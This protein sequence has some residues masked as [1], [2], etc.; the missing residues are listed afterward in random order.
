MAT[1]GLG[2]PATVSIL[3]T[4]FHNWDLVRPKLSPLLKC[5][6]SFEILPI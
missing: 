4:V 1:P 6:F 5:G 2:T 3:H